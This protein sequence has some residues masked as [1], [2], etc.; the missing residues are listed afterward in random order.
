MLLLGE[1]LRQA[2]RCPMPYSHL[3]D[4]LLPGSPLHSSQSIF[5]VTVQET[6][7]T[8]GYLSDSELRLCPPARTYGTAHPPINTPV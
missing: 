7:L 1:L 8:R 2:E 5:F 6:R 4:A 3:V